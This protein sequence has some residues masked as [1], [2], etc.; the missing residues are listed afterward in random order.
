MEGSDYSWPSGTYVNEPELGMTQI[1]MAMDTSLSSE[2]LTYAV[3]AGTDDELAAL[4]ESYAHLIKLRDEV[5]EMGVLPPLD[6][7]SSVNPNL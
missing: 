3:P 4:K 1:M 6:Q 5:V 7:W 2:G